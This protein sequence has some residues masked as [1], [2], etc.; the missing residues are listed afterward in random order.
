MARMLHFATC[1]REMR[2]G[3]RRWDGREVG[4]GVGWV[5]GE[6]EMGR[7]RESMN[8]D[9]SPG[10]S[11]TERHGVLEGGIKA[12]VAYGDTRCNVRDL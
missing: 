4:E 11:G 12:Q 7:G 8:C 9:A 1:G 5:A 10:E 2:R 6:R 3:R